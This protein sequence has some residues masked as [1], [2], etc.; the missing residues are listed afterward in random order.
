MSSP[1]MVPMTPGPP[2]TDGSRINRMLT[3]PARKKII[4]SQM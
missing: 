3:M 4:L 2:Q 1:H